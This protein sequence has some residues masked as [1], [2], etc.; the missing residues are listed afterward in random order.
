MPK[1]QV[2][3]SRAKDRYWGLHHSLRSAHS[4]KPVGE[5]VKQER[6]GTELSRVSSQDQPLTDPKEVGSEAYSPSRFYSLGASGLLCH[7]ISQS[8]TMGCF[9]RG[10]KLLGK[11][12]P[13]PR[14]ILRRRKAAGSHYQPTV[15]TTE[16]WG[17]P[18]GEGDLRGTTP[19]TRGIPLSFKIH[20]A[21]KVEA[22]SSQESSSLS[23]HGV[24][25]NVLNNILRVDSSPSILGLFLPGLLRTRQRD[26]VRSPNCHRHRQS[27]S[28]L[29]VANLAPKGI[30]RLFTSQ[31]G[32]EVGGRWLAQR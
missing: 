2:H 11:G 30:P 28:D 26:A 9:Q 12:L 32:Q 31:E 27:H 17:P 20:S 23:C 16:G 15:T 22:S 7:P 8:L 24:I 18:L 1:S 25:C 6:E 29:H 19:P 21:H 13:S 3:R 4:K 5:G 10:H 14:V